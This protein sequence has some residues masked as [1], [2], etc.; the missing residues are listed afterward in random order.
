M[1]GDG[2]PAAAICV[3]ARP[4]R[5]RDGGG[6]G[7]VCEV[8]RGGMATTSSTHED[9]LAA[10]RQFWDHAHEPEFLEQAFTDDALS[11][12]EPLGFITKGQAIAMADNHERWTDVRMSDVE[13][14]ELTPDCVALA[15]HGEAR[16][17]GADEPYRGTLCSIYVQRDGAWKLAFSCHQ[18]WKPTV[19]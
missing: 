10:E 2:A 11:V 19:G 17:S 6:A 18:P 12:I 1:H 4:D 8:Q 15:Y 9:V 16:R 13:V 3:G 14:R 7:V 5:L